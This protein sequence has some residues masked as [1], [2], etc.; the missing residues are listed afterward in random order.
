M[1]IGKWPF[2]VQFR[3]WWTMWLRICAID[4]RCDPHDLVGNASCIINGLFRIQTIYIVA[5][6][7]VVIFAL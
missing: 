6:K 4:Q 3:C 7:I 2:K 1:M 5:L